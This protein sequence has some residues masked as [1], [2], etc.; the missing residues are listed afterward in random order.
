MKIVLLSILVCLC[1][2][3]ITAQAIL[4]EIPIW[5]GISV[6]IA[7]AILPI[8]VMLY[9]HSK[10]KKELDWKYGR[11]KWCIVERY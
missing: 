1:T 8:P 7:S 4:S 3:I 10:L 9:Y 11:G 2:I 6:L 5:L